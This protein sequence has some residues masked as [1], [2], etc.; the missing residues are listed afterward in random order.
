MVRGEAVFQRVGRNLQRASNVTGIQTPQHDRHQNVILRATTISQHT[1]NPRR[2]E[3]QQL[4][5]FRG[6]QFV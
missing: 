2:V 1:G 5:L 6:F 4:A 3:R